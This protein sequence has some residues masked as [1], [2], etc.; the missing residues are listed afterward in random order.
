MTSLARI[1]LGRRLLG[2]LLLTLVMCASAASA[3]TTTVRL[4]IRNDRQDEKVITKANLL[5][6]M[7]FILKQGKRE[8]YCSY[9]SKNPA[10]HTKT[11]SFYLN[12]DSGQQDVDCDPAKSDFHDL[13]I[14]WHGA[15]G[16]EYLHVE[17]I[18]KFYVY[19]SADSPRDDLSVGQ[20]RQSATAALKEILAVIEKK[21]PKKADAGMVPPPK[22]QSPRSG[23]PK[24][25]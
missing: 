11:F 5:R 23:K 22:P 13:T 4:S 17:F 1:P 7:K 19:I 25:N 10:Y 15:R 21:E 6:V 2:L 16:L 8:T 14:R 24:A 9:Y 18:D 20:V 3:E 12:P